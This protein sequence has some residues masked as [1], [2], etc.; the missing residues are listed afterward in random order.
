[1]TL[2]L[3]IEYLSG[4]SC[5]SLGPDT[6][7]PDWPP[8]PDRVF[9][10]LVAS[11]GARGQD[12]REARA[13]EWLEALPAPMIFAAPVARRSAASVF[14]PPNDPRSDRLKNARGVLPALRSRQPRRFPAVRLSEPTVHLL[15]SGVEAEGWA[16]DAL[17]SLAADT[18]YVGH[19]T[20][21]TRCR[22][23]DHTFTMPKR[24]EPV[25][26]TR[27]VYR[28]RFAEL[29]KA[30]A[31]GRRPLAGSPVQPSAESLG[32]RGNH[33]DERWLVLEH[34]EGNMPDIRACA[35]VARTIRDAIL[36]G[37]SRI[38]HGHQI[39]EA[40]SGHRTDGRPSTSPHLAVVPLPFGGFPFADGRVLGFALVPPSGSGLLENEALRS[41][42][43]QIA[44]MNE[45]LGRRVILIR[46]T[47]SQD[48]GS[49][50]TIG[51]SPTLEYSRRSLDP[52]L[53][54]GNARVFATVTPIVLDRHLK[55]TGAEKED[56][57]RGL[58]AAACENAGLPRP[59]R[60]AIHKHAAFEG[61]PSAWPSGN[62]PGWMRWRLPRALASRQL[63]HAV[64][65]FESSVEGPVLIGAG[66]H[67]GLGLCRP[68]GEQST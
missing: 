30:F 20:S 53:Y 44:P 49:R 15:W 3:E 37:F 64:L 43:R 14:V 54:T 9:S 35:L 45:R 55:S 63:V 38:G 46:P 24:A 26:P 61:V 52:R 19:S 66:R 22:F 42:L 1:M 7:V 13:L 32:R 60:V 50:F 33:F 8:Q 48:S 31:A 10:A 27:T 58:I 41:A 65:S 34:V 2:L 40:V 56:E 67:A 17:N 59:E 36:S 11:W 6:P 21:L 23:I 4:V 28:G 29:R 18:A 47:N 68:L 25:A 12:D 16:L 51:L 57:I 39:P 5:S 62:A